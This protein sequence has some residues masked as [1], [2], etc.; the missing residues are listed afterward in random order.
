[1]AQACDPNEACCSPEIYE[2]RVEGHLQDRWA[3]WFECM[4]LA[5][6]DDGTTTIYGQLPDQ[7]ALHGILRRISN[8]NLKLISV[9]QIEESQDNE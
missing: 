8:M 2:I 5:R 6:E 1:M 9:T 3:E 7:S 4:Q